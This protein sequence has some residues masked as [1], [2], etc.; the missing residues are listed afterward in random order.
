VTIH[1]S[2]PA[3]VS[4]SVPNPNA[5]LRLFCFPYAGGGSVIYHHWPQFLPDAI[6]VCALKLPGRENRLSEPPFT[7][8]TPLVRTLSD[9]LQ[10]YL[11]RPF[12]FFG[13]SLG[14]LISFE[15][16][17]LLRQQ[18]RPM[19]LHLYAS[20]IRAPH[21]P[22]TREPIHALP[23]PDF[24]ERLRRINGTPAEILN[25]DALMQLLLPCLRADFSLSETYTYAPK[26]PLDCPITA[27]GG[28]DDPIVSQDTLNAWQ[29]HTTQA[30]KR[31]MFPGNHFFLHSKRQ[32]LLAVLTQDLT[33]YL[34]PQGAEGS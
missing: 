6:E 24:I 19:P 9:V 34:P 25:N 10:P 18:R 16:T 13:H 27:F 11:D 20:G 26:I 28:T 14:G 15:L 21:L 33:S 22:P 7:H 12:I 17:Q 2:A 23:T 29:S 5:E 30:F 8:M 3:W 31:H 32:S 4:R 1:S